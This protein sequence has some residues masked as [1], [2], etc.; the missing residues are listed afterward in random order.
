MVT[1]LIYVF[2][3]LLYTSVTYCNDGITLHA[4]NNSN[5][6][7]VPR[8]AAATCCV[9]RRAQHKCCVGSLLEAQATAQIWHLPSD[10][11]IAASLIVT[12]LLPWLYSLHIPPCSCGQATCKDTGHVTFA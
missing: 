1:T 4:D 5:E 9:R 3:L 11:C 12:A 7:E 8:P 6:G 10:Y 2:C